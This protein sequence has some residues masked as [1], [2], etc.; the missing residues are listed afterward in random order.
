MKITELVDKQILFL[1]YPVSRFNVLEGKIKELS[2]SKNF[3]KIN[4]DWYLIDNIRILELFS[5]KDKPSLGFK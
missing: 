4:N 1:H 2:P 3:V 5:D